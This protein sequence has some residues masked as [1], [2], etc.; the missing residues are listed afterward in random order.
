MKSSGLYPQTH[1]ISVSRIKK[2]NSAFFES[3]PGILHTEQKLRSAALKLDSDGDQL[4][5]LCVPGAQSGDSGRHFALRRCG[6]HPQLSWTGDVPSL[7]LA[8]PIS[9]T[10]TKAL[11]SLLLFSSSGALDRHSH[12]L[13]C[14]RTA[15]VDHLM[16]L[17]PASSFLFWRGP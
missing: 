4:Q 17:H 12:Q 2:S 1:R 5:G 7:S 10:G 9:K 3:A 14:F 8:L 15:G 13:G 11:V 6:V 16:G